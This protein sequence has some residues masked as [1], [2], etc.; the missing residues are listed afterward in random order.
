MKFE[1][2]SKYDVEEVVKTKDMQ[3]VK[4]FQ[5]KMRKI[6]KVVNIEYLVEYENGVRLWKQEEDLM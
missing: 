5:V 2:E 3:E 1:I 6:D 4:I